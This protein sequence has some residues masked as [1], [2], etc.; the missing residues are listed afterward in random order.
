V[1]GLND[2]AQFHRRSLEFGKALEGT[3]QLDEQF[4]PY[5]LDPRI[6]A[7]EKRVV[8][9]YYTMENLVKQGN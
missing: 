4:K 6:I 2:L 7:A 5:I 1:T 8:S 3:S 9:A